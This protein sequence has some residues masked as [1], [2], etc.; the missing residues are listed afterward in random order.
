MKQKV[1]IKTGI[2]LG[3]LFLV[4]TIIP[5][6]LNAPSDIAVY[7]GT[8][9][10]IAGVICCYVYFDKIISFFTNNNKKES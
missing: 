3:L 6:L 4:S 1:L 5:E 10:V 8:V 9:L 2:V 7:T